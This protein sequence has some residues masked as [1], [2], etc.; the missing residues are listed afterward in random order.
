MIILIKIII[1]L[2]RQ[3][4]QYLLGKPTRV[5]FHPDSWGFQASGGSLAASLN[6]FA[7]NFK[8]PLNEQETQTKVQYGSIS[9]NN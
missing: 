2:L 5:P 8:L 3:Y 6:L 4:R 1:T 9:L 7:V